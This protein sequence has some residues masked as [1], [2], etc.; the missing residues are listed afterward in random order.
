MLLRMCVAARRIIVADAQQARRSPR[1]RLLIPMPAIPP[2]LPKLTALFDVEN[3]LF[4]H[5]RRRIF[6]F[7]SLNRDT[8]WT[9]RRAGS[10][11]KNNPRTVR[12]LKLKGSRHASAYQQKHRASVSLPS[13]RRL[14]IEPEYDE[15][16]EVRDGRVRQGRHNRRNRSG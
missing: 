5:A 15:H 3:M 16:Q 4:V 7:A 14:E 1:Q 11:E 8:K 13:S 6:V 2:A 9:A 10:T 12:V